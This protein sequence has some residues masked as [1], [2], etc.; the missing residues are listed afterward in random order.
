MVPVT[1]VSQEWISQSR[2]TEGYPRR[3][4]LTHAERKTPIRSQGVDPLSK[5]TIR[6]AELL[7]GRGWI[8]KRTLL[9]ERQQESITEQIGPM[10]EIPTLKGG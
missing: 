9:A 10:M 8:K 5:L 7:V 4:H 2:S 1:S 6:K 3:L